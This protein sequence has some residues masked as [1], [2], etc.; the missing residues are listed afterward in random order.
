MNNLAHALPRIPKYELKEEVGHGG[1]ATVYRAHDA[2]LQRDV[3]VKV[4]HRHLRESA[5][6]G[7]RFTAEA[8]AVAKLRHPNIVEIYD[9]SDDD[10]PERY[11]VA[12]LVPGGSLRKVLNHHGSFPA[13]I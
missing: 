12:E 9:V 4:I 11:L 10:A 3:A 13:E 1:M 5:E 7:R 6:V 8:R 2:R